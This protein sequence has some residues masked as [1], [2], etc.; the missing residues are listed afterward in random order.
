MSIFKIAFLSAPGVPHVYCQLYV[1]DR[2]E[3]TW[4]CC[5]KFTMRTAEFD[6][7]QTACP[8]LQFENVT[9]KSRRCSL[10]GEEYEGHGNN[11][12]PF[13]GRCCEICN[14]RYVLPA[15]ARMEAA[16]DAAGKEAHA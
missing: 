3:M 5:G 9:P 11:A 2:P 4:A 6:D 13:R 7:F 15:R 1:A 8:D 10:C 14:L 16:T 12:E